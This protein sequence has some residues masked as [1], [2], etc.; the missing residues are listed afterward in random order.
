MV[1][2]LAI[3]LWCMVLVNLASAELA[4]LANPAQGVLHEALKPNERE[5]LD[6]CH[7]RFYS[8]GSG[9]AVAPAAGRPAY[10][11]EFAHIG[12]IG[13]SQPAGTVRWSCGG[14]LM[15]E[16]FVLTA[17]YCAADLNNEPP[18]VVRFGDLNLYNS[19]DDQ[20][21]QQYKIAEILRHPEHRFS[22]K[23][24]DIAL[25]KLEQRITLNE[26]VAPACLWSEEEL[27]F[28]VLEAAVWGATG[29]GQSQT[30]TLL[31]V[32]LKPVE[33]DRCDQFYRV[34]DR[35]LREGLQDYQL[36]AGDVKMDTCPG[37]S[38]GPLQVKLL[39][40]AKVTPFVVAVTSFGSACGQ[41]TPG[42]YT[43]V[44]KYAPW[45]RSVIAAH[46]T[47]AE[48]WKFEPY[49]CA[50][51]YVQLREY[52]PDV[53]S[54]KSEGHESLS[55]DGVHITIEDS[56]STVKIGWEDAKLKAPDNCYG[57]L[58]DEDTVLTL[59]ECTSYEGLPAT[60]VIV[61]DDIWK[62]IVRLYTHPNYR[63]GSHYNNIAIVKL[64]EPIFFTS[65]YF[66][67]ACPW[68]YPELP[69][70]EF[71]VTGRGRNDLNTVPLYDEQVIGIDARN[72]SLLVRSAQQRDGNCSL[73]QTHRQLFTNDLSDEHLCFGHGTFLVP[74]T[75]EQLFGGPIQRNLFR[76]SKY[77]KH[78][79][80]L[81]LLGRDCGFGQSA[82]GV[83]LAHHAEWLSKVLLPQRRHAAAPVQ[84]YNTDLELNDHC[85]R[86]D[87]SQGVCTEL[88]RCPKVRYSR[89]HSAPTG[90]LYA[91][92]IIM[93]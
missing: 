55:F 71:E 49:A 46:E 52:E 54:R 21:A 84:F 25:I 36:C 12:T 44:S 41:S 37:D 19:T 43:K 10:L 69:D 86:T 58:I 33:R 80:V 48:E 85:R 11:R 14:S 64:K 26:T 50:L 15:W 30:P 83:R 63:S 59:A 75:C 29:F 76:Y 53:V 74:D 38:G 62:E 91:V 60:H 89:L 9:G 17:A 47:D 78:V 22:A 90:R 32:S 23:Y 70:P 56:L 5:T 51:R 79:Y 7:L 88:A 6:D 8:F 61:L 2:F 39:H 82:V 67:P 72:A 20:F 27:R 40:N 3:L 87:G 81:N 73:S 77:F 18:D 24:H 4:G 35:G 1:R 28:D 92:R 68:F 42:V 57:V 66:T 93:C 13:W 65:R 31:K 45:I 16:N 34:G